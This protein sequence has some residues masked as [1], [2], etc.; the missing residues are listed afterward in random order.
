MGPM[1]DKG[2]VGLHKPELQSAFSVTRRTKVHPTPGSPIRFTNVIT[3]LNKHYNVN[4]GK[5]ICHIPGTY[6]FV[7]HASSEENLCITLVRDSE[8][9]ASFCDHVPTDANQVSSGGLT[10]YLHK[11]QEIW[12][13]TNDYKGMIGVANRQ[14]VFSGFLLYPH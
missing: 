4:T 11:D 8:G 5:F 3:N 2:T 13:K 14:S 12:L 1:G 6:Y 9:L 7:Y 10:V